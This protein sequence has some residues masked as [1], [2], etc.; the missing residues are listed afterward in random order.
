MDKRIVRV[1]PFASFSEKRNVPVS[2]V[3]VH[4]GLVY[5]SQMPPYDPV[6]GE[7]RRFEVAEQMELVM[8]QMRK[9]LEA[10]GSNLSRV[11]QCS[12]YA[13]DPAHFQIINDVYRR[14]FPTDPPAR[15]LIF[16]S[17]WHGP[18]DVEVDCI[19]AA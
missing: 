13:N 17:G 5:V 19:A 2:S 14:F 9:C 16:V 12:V 3:V 1:E 15:K 11:I 7:V 10:A 18:F 8:S 6:T 4:E